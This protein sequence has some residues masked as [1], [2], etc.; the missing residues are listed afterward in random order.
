MDTVEEWIKGKRVVDAGGGMGWYTEFLSER[1][2]D[3][4]VIGVDSASRASK[5]GRALGNGTLV[6][7][8]ISS[9]PFPAEQAIPNRIDDAGAAHDVTASM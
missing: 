2:H 9:L 6:I 8:D 1:N 4:E 3:G 5:K 7:G